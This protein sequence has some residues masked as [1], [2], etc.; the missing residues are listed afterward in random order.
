MSIVKK[1]LLWFTLLKFDCFLGFYM[2]L[3]KSVHKVRSS[4][5]TF[6]FAQRELPIIARDY[7]RKRLEQLCPFTVART[8]N[9]L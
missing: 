5:A 4:L 3:K 1:L 6:L 9:E 2:V 8:D 7:P